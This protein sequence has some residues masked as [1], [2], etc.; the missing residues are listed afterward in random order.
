MAPILC[1][2]TSQLSSESNAAQT[3]HLLQRCSN[4][5]ELR[6]IHGQM[7]KT[8]LIL[9][10][11]P[12]SKLLA[13]CASPNSGSLA[14]ARTVFDRIFR[15]NTFMWNTM[16]RGYS[17]SKEPEEALLLYHHMLYHSVPHNAYT[18]PF[19]LKACSSMSALEETQQ[20]HAHIIKMGFGSEIYTT[21]SL[22]NV[23]SK[24]GDI[25]SARL[26]FDQVDQRDTEALNLFHRMQTAGIKLDNVALVST[27][28]ACADLGV[29]DQGKW[30]HAYIKKHEIEIDP[31][32]GCVLIDMYAKCGDLEEAIEV[33]RKM[34][35]KGV[36]VWTAMISGYAIHGRG[37]EALEWFMKMQTAGVEPN[38]MTFTGILTAC[39]HAG[40][41]HEAKLLFE[42]MERIHGFKPSIEHYGCMV[43]LLG[44][45]GLLKEAEELIENMPVKPNAAIWG[46]LLNACHIHGNLELGK[47]IGKILIQVDPGHGGRYIH[48][49]SI[50]AAA[51]EWNQAARVRRQMKEQGVSKL[52]GC[53][54]ISVNGT[55]HEFLAGDESHPQIKEIDH[56]LEQIVERLREEGY[57]PKLGDLLLDLEDKE[58]ETAIHHHSEKLAVTFGLIS[59]KPGMTIR[60]VK[61]L[62]VC[63]DCHTVIKLISKVY[64]RE[65]LMRDRTRFH[66]FKDGNCT[67]GD[68]W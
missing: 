7:L 6:Q 9:D 57:K 42:S 50:H 53:S 44:R 67:C 5:E 18:F 25:K 36:S 32:L 60:I 26:L 61:N 45:A 49:A 2:P 48:L 16:I 43:D 28:Q 58:K 22:L 56:M 47:Q 33:F 10:E 27:L 59:T 54:V 4:M 17:N 14:Y 30:I 34:E 39:S 55:A 1:T 63:E 19:L 24:S 37:R 35:E 65:I 68:Y 46:A 12:A 31:I 21:N 51:G 15:P 3:L 20:I 38:Q 64:A 66:L 41:V 52:P 13:F 11:I 29:L 23:Y 62:R 8:G 40:L